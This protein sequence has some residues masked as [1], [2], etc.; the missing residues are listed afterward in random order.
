MGSAGGDLVAGT[1]FALRFPGPVCVCACVC[2][3]ALVSLISFL[4]QTQLGRGGKARV[5]LQEQLLQANS[6]LDHGQRQLEEMKPLD[7]HRECVPTVGGCQVSQQAHCT[8]AC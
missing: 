6:T 3:R 1:N 5:E 8:S 7:K 2:V 4:L